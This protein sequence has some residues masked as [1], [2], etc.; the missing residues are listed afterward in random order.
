ML[1]FLLD[2]NIISELIK[3]N[4]DANVL[5]KFIKFEDACAVSSVTIQEL[6]YGLEIMDNGRKKT[7]LAESV[8]LLK[9]IMPIL[10]FDLPCAEV[11]G[12][13]LGKCEKI[14]KA[15]PYDDTQ[16]AATAIVNNLVLVTRNINDFKPMAEVFPFNYENW[17]E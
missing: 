12:Q 13:I 9:K 1:K 7:Q 4:P 11:A 2:T 14:G 6:V 15:R 17:F 3:T 5:A 10:D 16:I 8:E